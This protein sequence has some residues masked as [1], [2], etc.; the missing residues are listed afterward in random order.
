[1]AGNTTGGYYGDGGA[2]IAAELH[3]PYGVD[4]DAHGN[5]YIGDSGNNRVRMVNVST[6]NIFTVAGNGTSASG[7][8]GGPATSA[9]L[10][11]PNCIK[12]DQYGNIFIADANGNR[13]RKVDNTSGYIS[14]V[15]GAGTGGYSGD[16]GPATLAQLNSPNC[17]DV[18][19]DGNI[20]I[21]DSVNN[22]IRLV[23][24]TS[25]NMSTVAGNG[26]GA[27]GG[28]GGPA[29]NA[30][31]HSP[32][33]VV[34]DES[35]GNL[36]ISESAS[37]YVRKV[38]TTGYISTIAGNGTGG[39]GGDGGPATLAAINGPLAMV[40]DSAGQLYIADEINNRV[41]MINASGTI[42][43][44]AGNGDCSDYGDGGQA[45]NAGL[46][47][48]YGVAIG[49]DGNLYVSEGGNT[50]RKVIL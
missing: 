9:G 40:F 7:G 38:N 2:A 3:W 18:D 24:I 6:G 27:S 34:M 32:A 19:G 8:D 49:P 48:P 5:I 11:Y 22:R 47:Q 37:Y 39:Y 43:T 10:E 42:L 17:L 35:S 33:G 44:V 31:I 46:R 13:I 50:V 29:T 20:Y 1:M 4:L 16:G 23:N 41:R 30:A 15:A 21:A 26:T 28:D 14:T 25:G 45:T 36:Y 12:L